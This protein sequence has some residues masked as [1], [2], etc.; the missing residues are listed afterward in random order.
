MGLLS[1]TGGR[2][3]RAKVLVAGGGVA[4]VEA[5]LAL[6]ALAVDRVEIELLAPGTEYVDRP[7]A[8]A[9]PFGLGQA[10]RWELARI[11]EDR[12]ARLRRGGLAEVD[13]GARVALTRAGEELAYDVLLVAVGAR[14]GIALPGAV[15]VKGPGYT[16][17]FR[18]ILDELEDGRLGSLAFAVPPGATWPLPL[19]ELTLLTAT[20]LAERGR[21]DVRLRLVTPEA[22]PLEMFGAA[23]ST[24]VEQLLEERGIELLRL[25]HAIA[26]DEGRLELA[27]DRPSVEADRVVAMPGLRGPHISGLPHDA[28]G[29]VPIDLHGLVEGELD[30]Y[31]AGDAT[32]F[33]LKQGGIAAQQAD[34][35]AEAIAARVGAPVTPR[36]FEPVLRGMLLTGAVPRFLR[37]EVGSEAEGGEGEEPAVSEHA[38]WWPPTKLA[39]RYLSPYL[40]ARDAEE[41]APGSGVRVEVAV[42]H[43]GAPGVRRRAVI[44]P[45]SGRSIIPLTG[46]R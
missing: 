43:G 19:Y 46:G 15:T 45:G 26:A 28:A 1:D 40:A 33:P 27:G 29:F 37:T 4:A 39:G 10:R 32:T 23:A 16:R 11:V 42:P 34:A 5:L 31:A 18:A 3:D 41:R 30:V 24:A 13:A 25:S 22:A 8:V 36:P 38:L 44:A 12:G 6:G 21:H 20:F 7:L 9:E 14:A 35:A 17:R 2:G